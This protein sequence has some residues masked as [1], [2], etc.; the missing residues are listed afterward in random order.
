LPC[1][2]VDPRKNPLMIPFSN[3]DRK[4]QVLL[5]LLV[6]FVIILVSLLITYGIKYLYKVDSSKTITESDI[7]KSQSKDIPSFQQGTDPSEKSSCIST[8]ATRQ[9]KGFPKMDYRLDDP[10]EVECNKSVP[11]F[12]SLYQILLKPQVDLKELLQNLWTV[13]KYTMQKG[14][15]PQPAVFSFILNLREKFF[16]IC[17]YKLKNDP[18]ELFNLFKRDRELTLLLIFTGLSWPKYNLGLLSAILDDGFFH[19]GYLSHTFYVSYDS[20]FFLK[21]LMDKYFLSDIYFS[22]NDQIPN[23]ES[24]RSLLFL[25]EKLLSMVS[26]LN[27]N[28]NP[29]IRRR[30]PQ[31]E[32][33]FEKELPAFINYWKLSQNKESEKLYI[34]NQT[35]FEFLK[36]RFVNSIKSNSAQTSLYLI[37]LIYW[38]VNFRFSKKFK[39][40]LLASFSDIQ[41]VVLIMIC[42]NANLSFRSKRRYA[43]HLY[44]DPLWYYRSEFFYFFE[45]LLCSLFD[46]IPLELLRKND[47]SDWIIWRSYFDT[48][49]KRLQ[50]F[51]KVVF[52]SLTNQVNFLQERQISIQSVRQSYKEQFEKL[53]ENID[54]DPSANLGDSLKLVFELLKQMREKCEKDSIDY[55][56]GLKLDG[57]L[58]SWLLHLANSLI[59]FVS[60]SFN[61][62]D[63]KFPFE[64]QVCSLKDIQTFYESIVKS[65]GK[66]G[67]YGLFNNLNVLLVEMEDKEGQ[68]FGEEN[69]FSFDLIAVISLQMKFRVNL[70]L[71]A[72]NLLCN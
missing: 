48:V 67:F 64:E 53:L 60:S 70:E 18:N 39:I 16:S 52:S 23:K 37:P 22:E 3:R 1:E 36:S 7:S 5:G 54:P 15:K 31:Q 21:S 65:L 19:T 33:F 58:P 40:E 55:S 28:Q 45:Y 27:Q 30:P 69:P 50:K 12:K 71:I 56:E 14:Y 47:L 62:F 4:K 9:Y 61:I 42:S 46:S 38:S 17:S 29:P 6:I 24:C 20:L 10:V 25:I 2:N 43:K 26:A 11:N 63:L 34:S 41:N 32:M 8:V 59:C 72:K 49:A 44:S 51:D 35:D 66:K 57:K 68:P 13:E